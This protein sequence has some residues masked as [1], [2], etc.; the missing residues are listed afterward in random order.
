MKSMK[1]TR[2]SPYIS[3]EDQFIFLISPFQYLHSKQDVFFASIILVKYAILD[4]F[5]LHYFQN[6][7]FILKYTW[8]CDSAAHIYYRVPSLIEQLMALY[9]L[10]PKYFSKLSQLPHEYAIRSDQIRSVAQSCPTLCNPMNR[11][12]Q[13]S[14]SITNS[15]S[16]DSRPSSRWCHPAL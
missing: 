7:Y 11:A 9:D 13:A 10:P 12:R 14:L 6:H 2:S 1:W 15:W 5:Y 3:S 16:S 8:L 4:F